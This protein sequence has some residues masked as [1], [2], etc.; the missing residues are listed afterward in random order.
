ML[1]GPAPHIPRTSLTARASPLS[2]QSPDYP[3]H[4][5]TPNEA[6]SF[7]SKGYSLTGNQI[8]GLLLKRKWHWSS[9]N[10]TSALCTSHWNCKLKLGCQNFTLLSACVSSDAIS[11]GEWIKRLV[12][13]LGASLLGPVPSHGA[14]LNSSSFHAWRCVWCVCVLLCYPSNFKMITPPGRVGVKLVN[15]S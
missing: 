7:T 3:S 9:L 15:F 5:Q 1:P 8:N 11:S 6:L 10:I 4:N 13:A 14:W 2:S 12:S